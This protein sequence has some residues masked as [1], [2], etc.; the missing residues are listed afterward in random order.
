MPEKDIDGKSW[1]SMDSEK[2]EVD[3]LTDEKGASSLAWQREGLAGDASYVECALPRASGSRA[4][5]SRE[6]PW[7]VLAIGVLSGVGDLV[8]N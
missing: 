2:W 5:V 8:L 6:G 1:L 4:I 7:S 3:L